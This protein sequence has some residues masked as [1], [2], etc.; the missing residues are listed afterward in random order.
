MHRPHFCILDETQRLTNPSFEH[1]RST[2]RYVMLTRGQSIGVSLYVR[3]EI[4]ASHRLN[5]TN[6]QFFESLPSR[7]ITSSLSASL[8]KLS[9]AP[10]AIG[11]SKS[12]RSSMSSVP[13]HTVVEEHSLPIINEE[14]MGD[15]DLHWVVRAAERII[16]SIF[17]EVLGRCVLRVRNGGSPLWN[18]VSSLLYNDPLHRH[19]GVFFPLVN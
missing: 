19:R 15:I 14:E 4:E 9:I 10:G 8:S 13:S 3:L 1:L 18:I 17:S 11:R 2:C 12:Y 6:H 16:W 7:C 5:F